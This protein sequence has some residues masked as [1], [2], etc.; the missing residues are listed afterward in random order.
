MPAVPQ[1]LIQI[2]LFCRVLGKKNITIKFL[3]NI[4]AN[5]AE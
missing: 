1:K 3:K 2:P 5:V 4:D